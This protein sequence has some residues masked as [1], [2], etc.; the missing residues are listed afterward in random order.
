LVFFLTMIYT[1]TTQKVHYSRLKVLISMRIRYE[2]TCTDQPDE[3]HCS[4]H[5]RSPDQ[6]LSTSIKICWSIEQNAI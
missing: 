4:K 2:Y 6:R 3:D 5:Q 1:H